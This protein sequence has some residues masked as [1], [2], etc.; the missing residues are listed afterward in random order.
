M[1]RS[2]WGALSVMFAA[3]N[4]GS[5]PAEKD[6][7]C[8]GQLDGTA[9]IPWWAPC[10][11]DGVCQAEACRSATG[12]AEKPGDGRWIAAM[13]G[14]NGPFTVDPAG[15]STFA[16][17]SEHYLVSS[18]ASV[19]ECGAIQWTSQAPGT[20]HTVMHGG[21]ELVVFSADWTTYPPMDSTADLTAFDPSTGALLWDTELNGF[22]LND[23]GGFAGPHTYTQPAMSNQ[24]LIAIGV[25]SPS[26]AEQL[27]TFDQGGHPLWRAWLPLTAY[28]TSRSNSD[29]VM[30]LG[31]DPVFDPD[32]R[33][34]ITGA[35]WSVRSN[36]GWD[37]MLWSSASDGGGVFTVES[38][39][40]WM[41]Q[42]AVG[43]G[44]VFADSTGAVLPDGGILYSRDPQDWTCAAPVVDAND[45]V[46]AQEEWAVDGGIYTPYGTYQSEAIGLVE[47]G[48]DG[49]A[50]RRQPLWGGYTFALGN[51]GTVF[52]APSTLPQC[53][54]DFATDS[55]QESPTPG[56][57]TVLAISGGTETT[58][59]AI[60]AGGQSPALAL[61]PGASLLVCGAD[62]A[63]AFF[64]GREGPSNT[65]PWSR[66]RGSNENRS[67]PAPQ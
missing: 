60:D 36:L 39:V 45:D 57:V 46:F 44:F 58:L 37:S 16:M 11:R 20:I 19:D 30:Q 53:F 62:S 33:L 31:Q 22:L 12:E 1:Q 35:D 23:D 13:P 24:G 17:A 41:G 43:S 18:L 51:A 2:A 42:L 66:A 34:Y 10:A 40:S 59:W 38:D 7:V 27:L 47:V 5:A 32:G 14:C 56:P 29:P 55:A 54:P 65:A 9:C 3:C 64:A 28:S 67:C 21:E 8:Q 15:N 48:A 26:G 6:A 50:R 4:G 25:F 49:T 63:Q 52:A 61:T